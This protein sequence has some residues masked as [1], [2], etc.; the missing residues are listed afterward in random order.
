MKI[1]HTADWHVKLGQ[2]HV[3][4]FWQV[5]RFKM[6]VKEINKA[7]LDNNC[8]LIIIGGD[9]FDAFDP[10]A[11]EIEL[12]Y[13]LVSMLQVKTL[14]HSGNHEMITKTKSV[15]AH[16]AEETN[17]GNPL[18]E[19]IGSV[20]SQD[21]DIVNY[22]ELHKKNWLPSISKLCFTHVR[23]AIPPHVTPEIDLAKFDVYDL[24]IAGDLH[25][26]QNTQATES[27]TPIV[28]PGSPLTSTFH[29][30]RT[31]NT[32]G[33]IIVDTDTLGYTWYELG[34]LPQ[35]IRKTISAT[36]EMVEDDYDRVIYEVEGD[37]DELRKVKDSDLLDKKLSK[38]V[39]KPAVID[40]SKDIGLCAELD[41]YYSKVKK[42]DVRTTERLISRF[43][44]VI[45]D[46]N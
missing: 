9:V 25:S 11:E 44:K 4:K 43:K 39:G 29:R 31:K 2:K 28:Y 10:S 5:S 21:F 15:L 33:F 34:H 12:Y 40:L 32:N 46:A 42:L 1:L 35:L 45:P 20:R 23:G 7:A 14:I 13:S 37:L 38:N 19:V 30:E 17:R 41:L 26:Y 22:S 18:V 27:G 24:V 36:D 3:P 6:M 16:V 8:D